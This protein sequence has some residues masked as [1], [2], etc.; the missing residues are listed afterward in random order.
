MLERTQSLFSAISASRIG[1]LL[2]VEEL[3][4]LL[5]HHVIHFKVFDG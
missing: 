5:H 3:A 2:A 1:N 4:E